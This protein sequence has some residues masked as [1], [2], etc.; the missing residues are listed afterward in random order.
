MADPQPAGASQVDRSGAVNAR[1]RDVAKWL[2]GAVSAVGAALIAGSQLSSI[3]KL[4]VC[5]QARLECMRAPVATIGVVVGLLS[6]A[7]ALR[8][9][10]ELLT[11]VDRSPSE[12]QQEWTKGDVSPVHKY[13]TAN[14]AYLQGFRDFADAMTQIQA[15]LACHDALAE[16]YDDPNTSDAERIELVEEMRLAD[17]DAQDLLNRNE[18][19]MA[20]ANEIVHTEDFR[21]KTK[22]GFLKAAGWAA[23]GILLFA[24]GANPPTPSLA[25]SASL[26]GAHLRG[27]DLSG[28]K[29]ERADLSGADLRGANLTGTDLKGAGLQGANLS[30]VL[31][32]GTTCPDGSNSDR[33]AGSC[34]NHLK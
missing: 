15:G 31:W 16:K 4:T 20:I 32:S 22:G 14:P 34:V 11:P 24:W 5:F 30:G 3:G 12:L 9:G 26:R 28:D 6:I 2:I 19:V 27:V 23:I 8:I 33:D 10:L 25:P 21:T 7:A 17:G 29:L 1:L 18:A 13:F